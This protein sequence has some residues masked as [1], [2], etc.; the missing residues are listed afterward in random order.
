MGHLAARFTLAALIAGLA[1]TS[2]AEAA[3]GKG[4]TTSASGTPYLALSADKTSTESGGTV[5]LSWS[6]ANVGRCM[7]S[8]N[9][10]GRQRDSGSYRTGPLTADSTFTLTCV[11]AVGSIEQTVAVTIAEPADPT[12]GASDGTESTTDSGTADSGTT[13]TPALQLQASATAIR[14]GESVTLTWFGEAVSNCQ[15]SGSWSGARPASGSESRSSLTASENYTLTCDSAS[16]QIVA[17]TSVQVTSSG[18]LI[19][20]QPPQEKIDGT[21]LTGLSGYRIYVGTLTQAYNQ[22]IELEDP[23]ATEHFVDLL[24]GEY[25]IAMTALDTDGNESAYS[26]EVRRVVQ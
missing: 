23:T 22:L 26:N 6:T 10:S 14:T 18:A 19:S 17:M 11:T 25:Y 9:W 5:L 7:A 8:G 15:A 24:P 1:L 4:G 13:T 21:L 3:N 12:G 20:W 16:G 2:T